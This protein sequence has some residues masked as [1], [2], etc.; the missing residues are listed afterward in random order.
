M[1]TYVLNEHLFCC[2]SITLRRTLDGEVLPE[3]T[4]YAYASIEEYVVTQ[5]HGHWES[6][7]GIPGRKG[8][9]LRSVEIKLCSFD[10]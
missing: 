5:L 8:L 4:P 2:Q 3:H 6:G 9:S 1:A 7:R 10:A